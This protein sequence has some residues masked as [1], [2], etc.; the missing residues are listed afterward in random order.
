MRVPLVP[1]GWWIRLACR[2]KLEGI[3]QLL[4]EKSRVEMKC[5]VPTLADEALAGDELW[6][7]IDYSPLRSSD[8]GKSWTQLGNPGCNDFVELVPDRDGRHAFAAAESCDTD[9]ALLESSDGGLDWHCSR[10]RDGGAPLNGSGLITGN[11][12]KLKP[13][14]L[15]D[16]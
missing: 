8:G 16:N 2:F 9:C 12:I 4:L 5:G 13:R 14:V 6:V 7:Q 15:S 3:Y 10:H 11:E 1:G